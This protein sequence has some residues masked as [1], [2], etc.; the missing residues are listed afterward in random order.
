MY[1]NG[2]RIDCTMVNGALEGPGVMTYPD[3]ARREGAYVDNKMQGRWLLTRPD[4]ARFEEQ[5]DRNTLVS[6]TV[7]IPAPLP[8]S[9]PS[10]LCPGR[11]GGVGR[12]WPRPAT[13]GGM[14][15]GTLPHH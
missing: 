8:R 5:W 1:T 13:R 4:G 9:R 14:F 12:E 10:D 7:R 6:G 3:G 15:V 11:R 2:V